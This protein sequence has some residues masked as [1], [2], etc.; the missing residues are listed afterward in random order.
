M[1]E[2]ELDI[3][4]A[5][6][7][8]EGMQPQ[9]KWGTDIYYQN[10]EMVVA[11]GGFK[12]YFSIWFYKG[13]FLQDEAK[14]LLNAQEGKTKGLRQWRFNS[15]DEID[16]DLIRTYV[17]EAMYIAEQNMPLPKLETS[18]P[19]D[20][21]LFDGYL[22]NNQALK[23]QFDLLAPYKRKEYIEYFETAKREA[24]KIN[25]IDKSIPLILEGKGLNDKYKK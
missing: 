8:E 16:I 2:K 10:N 20:S 21:M 11:C 22:A 1:W 9:L 12:N 14:K 25:R 23:D 3:I 19:A 5:I 4:S 18:L 15:I 17:K 6:F 7:K 13:V 24:T